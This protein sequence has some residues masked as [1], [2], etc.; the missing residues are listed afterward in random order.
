MQIGKYLKLIIN[1]NYRG[2]YEP[3]N[4]KS[5]G[6]NINVFKFKPMIEEEIS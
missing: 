4:Y 5:A 6:I 3:K 2:L 1:L